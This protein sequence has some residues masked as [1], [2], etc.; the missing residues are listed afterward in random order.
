[1]PARLGHEVTVIESV[2]GGPPTVV[3][4]INWTTLEATNYV[5]ID[6]PP[7]VRRRDLGVLVLLSIG[8][9]WLFGNAA[10]GIV[11]AAGGM[12]LLV[13]GAMRAVWRSVQARQVDVAINRVARVALRAG[14]A[15]DPSP[16]DSG[17]VVAF[18]RR[19]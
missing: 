14:G 11:V 4:L 6:P 10:P 12:W 13:A 3:A 17:K 15:L 1:M 8:A 18:R 16:R 19:R 7:L 9:I 5:E 2:D